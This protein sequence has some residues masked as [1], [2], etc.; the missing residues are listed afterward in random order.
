MAN[1]P[2]ANLCQNLTKDLN[3]G[4]FGIMD[5]LENSNQRQPDIINASEHDP[6]SVLNI[7]P[8]NTDFNSQA[9]FS[10]LFQQFITSASNAAMCG[11]SSNGTQPHFPILNVNEMRQ[12]S[13]NP[14]NLQ[15][16]SAFQTTPM[17]IFPWLN[18]FSSKNQ[19]KIKGQTDNFMSESSTKDHSKSSKDSLGSSPQASDN[20]DYEDRIE[21][22]KSSDGDD[23]QD[24]SLIIDLNNPNR[25][26]K[27][28]TV[29]SRPQVSKLE[30]TFEM[31][32]YLSSQERST[33]AQQLKLTE[34][35]VKIWFQNR[36][37]K[38]KRQVQED[39]ASSLQTYRFA[40]ISERLPT[41]SNA[42]NVI[43]ATPSNTVTNPVLQSSAT[44]ARL[45][46]ETYGALAAAQQQMV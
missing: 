36:R 13:S 4:K 7:L 32:R 31:K 9:S 3:R 43:Q 42:Y 17:S 26:K 6:I 16:P 5:I 24:N 8:K 30:M 14:I 33:L 12:Q 37:N 2:E 38:Y 20:E 27:T 41:T 10:A 23:S 22:A 46:I 21:I 25:K 39:E 1:S 19:Q 29:F 15:A 35:Q 45:L 44:A 34:T 40:S 18:I 11:E 28:R